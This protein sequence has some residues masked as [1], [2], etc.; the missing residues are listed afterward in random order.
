MPASSF[1]V[2]W[3]MVNDGAFSRGESPREPDRL[4][5]LFTP[6]RQWMLPAKS[7]VKVVLFWDECFV[8]SEADD[9]STHRSASR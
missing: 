3:S 4:I 6:L 9:R 5:C 1:T 8:V 2:A 7:V